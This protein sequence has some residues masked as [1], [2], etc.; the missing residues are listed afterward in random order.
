[1]K[2]ERDVWGE[3]ATSPAVLYGE[4][5]PPRIDVDIDDDDDF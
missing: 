3:S 5:P 1:M 2:E 4:C